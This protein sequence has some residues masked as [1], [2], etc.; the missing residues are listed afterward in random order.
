MEEPAM[1]IHERL[2]GAPGDGGGVDLSCRICKV[3]AEDAGSTKLLKVCP[4]CGMPLAEWE[5]EAERNS[6]LKDF[7]ESVKR[8]YGKSA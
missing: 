1:A 5:T 8:G 6:E 4:K 3:P 2:M 7:E